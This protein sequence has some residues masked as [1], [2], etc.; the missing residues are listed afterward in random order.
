MRPEERTDLAHR[1]RNPLFGSFQENLLT[2]A[3][4]RKERGYFIPKPG[5][6]REAPETNDV[7]KDDRGLLW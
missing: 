5:D 7:A 1:Q 4:N 3:V 2:S 6:G